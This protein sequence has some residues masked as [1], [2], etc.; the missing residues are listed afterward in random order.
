M[1][2]PVGPSGAAVDTQ[3]HPLTHPSVR[4]QRASALA[5]CLQGLLDGD[6]CDFLIHFATLATFVLGIFFGT[7]KFNAD[8]I[9]ITPLRT[10]KP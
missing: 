3:Q 8:Q 1:L 7:L 6:F 2:R 10:S 4:G 9:S 5:A